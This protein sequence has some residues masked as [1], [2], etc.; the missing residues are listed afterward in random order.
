M[1][2]VVT[3][4]VASAAVLSGTQTAPVT[5]PPVT[6][7][8]V[9][10][11]PEQKLSA[12]KAKEKD[13]KAKYDAAKASND[14]ATKDVADKTKK[15]EDRKKEVASR[16]KIAKEATPEKIDQTKKDI[17]K[18]AADQAKAK[19]SLG[20]ANAKEKETKASLDTATAEKNKA[21]TDVKAK[22]EVKA[23]SDAKVAETKADT[24]AKSE[25]KA[26]ADQNVTE[27]TSAKKS[28][29][30]EVSKANQQV[31]KAKEEEKNL[32]KTIE[33]K[34]AEVTNAK[35]KVADAKTEVDKAKRVQAEKQTDLIEAQNALEA[36]KNRVKGM[37]YAKLTESDKRVI[38][39]WFDY[40]NAEKAKGRSDV[41]ISADEKAKEMSDIFDR[42]CDRLMKEEKAYNGDTEHVDMHNL[43]DEQSGEIAQYS[44]AVVNSIRE[45]LGLE[46][47]QW[48]PVGQK[49]TNRFRDKEIQNVDNGTYQWGHHTQLG[50]SGQWYIKDYGDGTYLVADGSGGQ[51]L[52][53]SFRY[54]TSG[55]GS[56]TTMK[57]VKMSL[58]KGILNFFTTYKADTEH[59]NMLLYGASKRSTDHTPYFLATTIF[60]VPNV[61]WGEGTVVQMDFVDACRTPSYQAGDMT[62]Y[63]CGSSKKGYTVYD[64][65]TKPVYHAD[66][67]IADANKKVDNA[68]AALEA[69]KNTV[70]DKQ[71]AL[72]QAEATLR[73]A[74]AE[75]DALL[76]GD[77]PLAIAQRKLTEA[78]ARQ[79]EAKKALDEAL[80]RQKTAEDAYNKAVAAQK[81]A[82]D[83][84]NTDT[85]ALESAKNTLRAKIL[86]YDGAKKNHD[87]AVA[88]VTKYTDE[89]N[90]LTSQLAQLKNSLDDMVNAKPRLEKAK[91]DLEKFKAE[92]ADAVAAKKLSDTQLADLSKKLSDAEEEL[93]QAQKEYDLDQATKRA[94]AIAKAKAEAEQY[95]REHK[96]SGVIA[97]VDKDGHISYKRVTNTKASAQHTTKA[98]KGAMP[99]TAD[100]S[101]VIPAMTSLACLFGLI[102]L[103][104][105]KK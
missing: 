71:A 104:R 44:A 83:R 47:F 5:Q 25:T 43:T 72:D 26:S 59:A 97:V 36:T 69:A 84:A 34:K 90:R 13:A 102:G 29:D 11:N 4:V 63:D 53:G 8:V 48:S 105:R 10:K 99:Q 38:K 58:L 15:V 57:D 56:M 41:E 16:E 37:P 21:D 45:Q 17:D 95:N 91:T 14:R 35:A 94:E 27:K 55:K 40:W 1:A 76:N 93:R 50:E 60:N 89:L 7:T 6:E 79:A 75:L 32:A 42:I 24:K 82:E 64:G 46:K 87:A 22:S 51:V 3:G 96:N 65:A 86:A 103:R 74:Q 52:S 98:R 2:N 68:N 88:D 19:T 49:Y 67:I 30:T 23:K 61:G 9:A 39:D 70:K 77:S 54:N 100:T 92:L 18:T 81:A 101:A 78:E 20:N 73:Q 12:A 31:A 80:A 66:E 85:N 28:A 33:N 62:L